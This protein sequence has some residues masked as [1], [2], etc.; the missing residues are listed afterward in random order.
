MNELYPVKQNLLSL[1]SGRG[2]AFFT[3]LRRAG[4]P[5]ELSALPPQ[6]CT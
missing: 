1:A 4:T 6:L 2:A 5:V 3:L